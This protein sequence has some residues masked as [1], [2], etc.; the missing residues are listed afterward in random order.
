MKNRM[1]LLVIDM[2]NDF[3]YGK[4]RCERCQRIIPNVRKLIQYSRE[5]GIPVIYVC[6]SHIKNDSE[7]EKWPE[8][9]V[10]GTKGSEIIPE[11]KP[12]EEDFIIKKRRYSA[13]FQTGLDSL[14]RELKIGEIIICGILTDICVQHTA[15]DAF[16]RGY[17]TIIPKECTES[18][19]DEAKEYSFRVME[20]LYNTRIVSLSEFIS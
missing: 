12:R 4:L 18:L 9:A 5:N 7:F 1:A 6:D 11:L 8:H 16:Y 13:F 15:A 10:Q 2:L 20:N 14:L 17:K 19:S 3:L